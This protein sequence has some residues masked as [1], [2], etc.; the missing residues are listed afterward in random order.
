MYSLSPTP[1]LYHVSRAL[2]SAPTRYIRDLAL[3]VCYSAWKRSSPA[4]KRFIAWYSLV[5]LGTILVCCWVPHSTVFAWRGLCSGVQL[6]V[7]VTDVCGGGR[8]WPNEDDC[9]ARHSAGLIAI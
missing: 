8:E 5:Q 1:V 7:V 3:G 2:S 4:L 6:S 9:S